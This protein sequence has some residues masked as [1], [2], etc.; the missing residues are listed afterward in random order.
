VTS[1]LTRGSA[2]AGILAGF[3]VRILDRY[4]VSELGG[5]FS[6]GLSAFTLIF[7]ATQILAI[8]R[9]VSDRH[10]P[11][12][13]VIAYFLWQLP[14]I[15]VLVIPM[16]MLLG[17]L[18]ALQRLSGESEITA[19]KAG[20]ISLTRLVAPLLGVGLVVSLLALFLQEG[21][22]PYANDRANYL[23]EETIEHIGLF[24]S[25]SQAVTTKLPNGGRQLTSFSNYESSTQSLVNV[26]LIQYDL[27]NRPVLI[28][29]SQRAKYEPPT[30]TFANATEYHFGADGTTWTQTA[31]TQQ[32]D[33]GQKP[34]QIMQRAAGDNP[35]NMSRA[36]IRQLIA[37]GQLSPGELRTYQTSY[38]EKLARPF[39]AFVFTLIAVPF[40]LRSPR[41]GGGTGLGFGL[42][43][44][45][46]FVYFVI[47]SIC[48]AVFTG[49]GG[50]PGLAALGA[51][52]PNIIFTAIGILMLQ[53]AARY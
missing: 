9:L 53:R 50:G 26:T 38:Q 35:E 49:L 22:V 32:W 30:W 27:A 51:W 11:L 18:L 41:A 14:A 13:A 36:Q 44:A 1:G 46:V 8:S 29:F 17:M 25:G 10:A 6:F 24:G 20:G 33:I 2:V 52:L 39:A 23:R 7:A 48:S 43:V 47:A 16:A 3:R 37:T 19:L 28:V 34:S 42:A 4:M 5:P 40:G 21:I 45:I 31:P 15:V 12:G